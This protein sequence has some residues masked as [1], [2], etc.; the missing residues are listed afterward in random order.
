MGDRITPIRPHISNSGHRVPRL[1]LALRKLPDGSTNCGCDTKT[2]RAGRTDVSPTDGG[3]QMS[4]GT[5]QRHSSVAMQMSS[6]RLGITLSERQLTI[7]KLTL[8]VKE[9]IFLYTISSL[10]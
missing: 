2:C 8:S 9:S 1:S 10:S 5:A 6:R 3:M 7:R 4:N